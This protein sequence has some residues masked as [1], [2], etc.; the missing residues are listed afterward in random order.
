[1]HLLIVVLRIC[2]CDSGLYRLCSGFCVFICVW[3]QVYGNEVCSC[4]YGELVCVTSW[5]IGVVR[6]RVGEHA[7]DLGL[8]SILLIVN[9][10][11]VMYLLGRCAREVVG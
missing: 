8:S 4:V 1:M 3:P 6:S 9:F 11:C 7:G 5:D 10:G 2:E